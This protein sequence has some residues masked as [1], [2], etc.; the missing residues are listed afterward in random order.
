MTRMAE[1]GPDAGPVW[2]WA[3]RI[4]ALLC[5]PLALFVA[6]DGAIA[7]WATQLPESVPMALRDTVELRWTEVERRSIDPA[8][9][10]A[11]RVRA[12]ASALSQLRASPLTASALRELG[13]I[14][15]LGAPNAGADAGD[16]QFRNAERVTRRDALN[17]LE[18]IGAASRAGDFADGMRHYDRILLTTPEAS[19]ALFP[20]LAI[21]LVDPEVRK[22]LAVFAGREWFSQFLVAAIDLGADPAAAVDMYARTARA[23]PRAEKQRVGLKLVAQLSGRGRLVEARGIAA[24]IPG[25][26]PAV[27]D[28]FAL[29]TITSNPSLAPLTWTLHNDEAVEST[30][31]PP[32]QLVIRVASG[33]S[34]IVAER[35]MLAGPGSYSLSH[36]VSDAS[37]GATAGLAWTVTCTHGQALPIVRVPTQQLPGDRGRHRF[38]ARIDVPAG[39]GAQSWQLTATP[40]DIQSTSSVTIERLALV[41]Q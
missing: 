26:G 19:A 41:P 25:I 3:L 15:S 9:V 30:F 38:S 22:P 11:N 37:G 33:R 12:K 10:A 40:E 4:A 18:L 32:G 14:A 29:T 23:I 8:W 16:E 21:A 39:C 27:R 34:S 28:Q 2:R 31:N 36:D 13:R 5:A 1:P 6:R 20:T 7:Y 24:T 35:L 17:Q